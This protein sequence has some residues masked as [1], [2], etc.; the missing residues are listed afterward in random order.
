MVAVVPSI[1]ACHSERQ[2]PPGVAYQG[3]V[4]SGATT[5]EDAGEPAAPTTM[6]SD[7]GPID[8]SVALETSDAGQGL[9]AS[10]NR[11]L[12]LAP[13]VAYTGFEQTSAVPHLTDSADAGT[14]HRRRRR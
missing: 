13:A 10:S 4:A 12:E 9:S 5:E 7:V 1:A 2:L 8:A 6:D 14:V 3:F 11:P